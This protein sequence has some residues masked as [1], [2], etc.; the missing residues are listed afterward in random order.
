MRKIY[1]LS[2]LILP[3][4]CVLG[5]SVYY[6][7]FDLED[8]P[9]KVDLS[10]E[11]LEKH[12]GIILN[13]LKA[14]ELIIN[15]NNELENYVFYNISI[16]VNNAD[17]IEKFNKIYIQYFNPNDLITFKCRITQ[18]NGKSVELYKGDMKQ[19]NEEG[20]NYYILALEG[21]EKN[22]IIEY[23]Y[24]KRIGVA[25][26]ASEFINPKY[27]VK[28]YI[29]QL[30]LPEN[31]FYASKSYNGMPQAKDTSHSNRN[32]LTFSVNNIKPVAEEKYSTDKEKFPRYEA[33]IDY[34]AENKSKKINTYADISKNMMNNF[35]EFESGDEKAINRVYKEL[36]L[37]KLGT[38]D[39]KIFAIESYIKNE[40]GIYKDPGRLSLSECLAK[41][42]LSEY[43]QNKLVV[44]LL[45][46]CGIEYEVVSTCYKDDRFFDP[47]FESYA[48]LDAAFFYI[49]ETKKYFMPN[50]IIYRY[51]EIPAALMGQKGLFIKPLVLGTSYSALNK[52]KTVEP[53]E[54][55]NNFSNLD[56]DISFNPNDN[57]ASMIVK[58]YMNG[59]PAV[60]VRPL[61]HYY[62]NDKRSELLASI[63]KNGLKDA[64]VS[65]AKAE[66]YN[67]KEFKEYNQPFLCSGIVET[68]EM[69]E[70]AGENY[71]IKIGN[72]IGA[73]SELYQE[74]QRSYQIY[75]G[76]P[77]SYK[78][79]IKFTVP[80]GYK[81]E[82]LEKLNMNS[83]L[84][85]ENETTAF[86]TSSYVQSGNQITITVNEVYKK[87][88]YDK[89]YFEGFRRVI[90]AAADFNKVS[91]LLKK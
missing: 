55:A 11:V 58:H 46:K 80:D 71:I 43:Y 67:L 38:I 77:H 75:T 91:L 19:V 66:N 28:K 74:G 39:E 18:A 52:I 4:S 89:K 62:D 2:L 73:Q 35:H 81:V 12:K 53:A 84:K 3:L 49:P 9:Q 56:C 86:F 68:K 37:E 33:R 82:G 48:Y 90:N 42:G 20:T 26:T 78:R 63:L 24:L 25:Y 14:K 83:E 10:D 1:F 41:K 13:E 40:M 27:Y 87:E 60:N 15:S 7:N 30:I 76:Y 69:S 34:N 44:A 21:L 50:S 70:V 32:F 31:L 29:S 54:G 23:Y 88:F 61:Y 57:K 5:Q 85:E 72:C 17:I 65:L 6:K 64:K 8:K 59:H 45:E 16:L 79:V 51:G 36:K 22:S 47:E